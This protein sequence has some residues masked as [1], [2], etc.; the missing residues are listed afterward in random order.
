MRGCE[1]ALN[2]MSGKRK[3]LLLQEL[4]AAIQAA[5]AKPKA[6]K[7]ETEDAVDGFGGLLNGEEPCF[8]YPKMRLLE[9]KKTGVFHGFCEGLGF[10]ISCG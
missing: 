4:K 7:P 9:A 6:K 1:E 8:G 2:E 10:G 5:A 3:V